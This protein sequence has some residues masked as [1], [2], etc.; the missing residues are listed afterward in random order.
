MAA[1]F[2][3]VAEERTDSGKGASRRLRR[4]GKVPAI[5]YGAGRVPRPVSFDLDVLMHKME[6]ESFFSSVLNIS[7]KGE[8]RQCILKDVQMHPAKRQVMHLDLQRIVADEKIR[9]SVPVHFLN[10]D[11][12]PGVRQD[13][14]TVAHVITDVEVSC[15]PANLPEY[16]EIDIGE[17]ELD[18]SLL[19]SDIVVPEEVEIPE[20][21]DENNPVVVTI[22]IVKIAPIEDE[23]EAEAVEGEGEGEEAEGETDAEATEEKDGKESKEGDSG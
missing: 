23:L 11:M 10:E 4:A 5:V 9:M 14:G 19:L 20:L 3:L 7:V 17:L 1:V 8:A 2:D 15:L 12:A 22:H 21:T 6:N 13:A 18:Q 16:L